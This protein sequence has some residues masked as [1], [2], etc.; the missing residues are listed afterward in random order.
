MDFKK[1]LPWSLIFFFVSTI[2]GSLF[3]IMHLP[4]A[5]SLITIGILSLVA[6]IIA[7]IY[8]ITSSTKIEGTEKYIWIMGLIFFGIFAGPIYILAYRKKII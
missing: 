6:F 2:F 7:S 8:E 4:F 3:K 5:T 1:F